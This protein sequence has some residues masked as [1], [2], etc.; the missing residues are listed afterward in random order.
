MCTYLHLRQANKALIKR[1]TRRTIHLN[2]NHG[3]EKSETIPIEKD[4]LYYIEAQHVQ[5]AR[6]NEENFLQ[7]G[8]WLHKSH[9][10]NKQ[11]KFAKDEVQNIEM[12]YT[13][14]LEKQRITLSGMN[15]VGEVKFT[16]SGKVARTAF[17]T[18]DATNKTTDWQTNFESMLTM[19]CAYDN[20]NHF[21]A[22]NFEDTSY[23]LDGMH[24][25]QTDQRDCFCGRRC[26]ERQ[27]RVFHKYHTRRYIDALKYNF[28]CFAVKGAAFS[29]RV[30][31]LFRC[32]T[33]NLDLG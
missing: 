14:E 20:T 8:L 30:Q 11:T 17:S 7:I 5:R 4:V 28:I 33:N 22:Q 21:E 24:A 16:Q 29:G 10:H 31:V 26:M 1:H 2:S 13:R 19:Q 25:W 18:L 6:K 3:R 12:F 23:V 9:Y 15:S 27:T 32:V